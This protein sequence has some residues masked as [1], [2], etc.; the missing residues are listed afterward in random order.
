[1]RVQAFSVAILLAVAVVPPRADGDEPAPAGVAGIQA[2]YDR[3]F[4]RELAEYL[5]KYPRADD[6]EQAYAALFNKA[7]EHDWFA[8]TDPLARHY[9][10][11]EPDGPVNALAQII[12]TMARAHAGQFD[13][14]L[15]QFKRLVQGLGH[16]DQ[17]EF[18]ASFAD[19]FASAAVT[20]GK[21][22]VA[23]EVYRALLAR[24]KDSA[25]LRQ[26]IEVD[27]KRLALV[28]KPAPAF[29][30]Q[31]IN[32]QAIRLADYRGKYVLVDFWA[33]WCAP[34]VGELPH[35]QAAYQAYRGA[36]FE[37]IGVSLDESKTA[38]AD[39]AKARKVPWP[40]I[41]NATSSA[42]LV[43][44]FGISSI[45]ATYLIDPQGAI[46]RMD[47]RGKALD[48]TLAPLLKRSA[49]GAAGVQTRATR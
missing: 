22:D 37:V 15:A 12:V 40:Q 1:V 24:F 35:L 16:P 27:L 20:A 8:E 42:D 25:N 17:E 33:T 6:R 5:Q 38:V 41:H 45:P 4:I 47:L 32:G 28:G 36:G 48:E 30:T 2:K 44:L 18:A 11:S 31:D 34:C 39:F 23:K 10:K 43:E 46:T 49:A 29:A 7:I 21:F 19:E 26:K 13:E 14:A 9:L 3:A